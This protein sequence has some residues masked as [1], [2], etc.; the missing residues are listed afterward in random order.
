VPILSDITANGAFFNGNQ[1]SAAALSAVI[2]KRIQPVK[3]AT[4]GGSGSCY[5]QEN[6]G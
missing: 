4:R 6:P 3:A 2:H 5:L 1:G